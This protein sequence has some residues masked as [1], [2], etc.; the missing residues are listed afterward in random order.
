MWFQKVQHVFYFSEFVYN[1]TRGRK[2]KESKTDVF[3]R[4]PNLMLFVISREAGRKKASFI[5]SK[6]EELVLILRASRPC[7]LLKR[8]K[9]KKYRR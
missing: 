5:Y 3:K 7:H 1:K 4:K 9:K 2:S 8:K 6:V